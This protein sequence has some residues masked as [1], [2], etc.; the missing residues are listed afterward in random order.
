[1]VQIHPAISADAVK[2]LRLRL[3]KTRPEIAKQLDVP[4]QT[5]EAV[6][7]AK[8][9]EM[10][11]EQWYR[12]RNALPILQAPEYDLTADSL[13]RYERGL[14]LA[15]SGRHR[16]AEEILASL[17]L[18]GETHPYLRTRAMTWVAGIRRD[19]FEIEGDFGALNLYEVTLREMVSQQ[20]ASDVT[21]LHLLLGA[22]H[23]M[24]QHTSLAIQRYELGLASSQSLRSTTRFHTRLGAILT[25]DGDLDA[26]ARHLNLSTRTSQ[27]LDD[28]FP[29]SF[30]FEKRAILRIAQRNIDGAYSDLMRARGEIDETM[31]LRNIQS[32]VVEAHLDAVVGDSAEA[33][34]VL[35]A[36]AGL[37]VRYDF[38]HQM[39]NI[40]RLR[41]AIRSSAVLPTWRRRA[42]P[43]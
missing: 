38:A 11:A 33:E 40:S 15:N 37:A 42:G 21:E 22:C 1:M 30:A 26:A 36:A 10:T 31:P 18:D 6:E 4:A 24:L 34:V 16:E 2:D 8:H 25:K 41:E 5:I 32:L 3:G 43:V 29:Y 39:Q 20:R 23:E 13:F 9:V 19:R 35:D 14:T 27:E 7:T 17:M 28:S 12:L